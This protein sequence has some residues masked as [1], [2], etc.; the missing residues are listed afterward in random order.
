MLCPDGFTLIEVL[1]VIV[2]LAIV[3]GVAIPD[4]GSAAATARLDAGARRVAD[5]ADWCYRSAIASG[6]VHAL[7]IEDEGRSLQ[8]V[9]ESRPRPTAG[10]PIVPVGSSTPAGTPP[11]LEPVSLPGML[12]RSLPEG[13]RVS[14]AS[15]YEEDL[16]DQDP[17]RVRILFFP[18]GTTEFAGIELVGERGARRK[19]RINGLSGRINLEEVVDAPEDEA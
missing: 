13:I 11:E 10:E 9:A 12:G 14:D 8:V 3:A 17:N 4:M 18:D 16:A 7:L 6:R 19:V 15:F 1:V 2:V 5:L